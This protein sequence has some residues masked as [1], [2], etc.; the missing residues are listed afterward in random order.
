MG[1]VFLAL[2]TLLIACKRLSK[3]ELDT[4]NFIRLCFNYFLVF[5]IFMLKKD[6]LDIK[7]F[8]N[9]INRKLKF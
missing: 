6:F 7:E 9:L 3:V 1:N 2:I 5:M 4:T 8:P